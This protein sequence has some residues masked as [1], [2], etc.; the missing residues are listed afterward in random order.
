MPAF[1]K[2]AVAFFTLGKRMG[3]LDMTRDTPE[4]LKALYAALH[5]IHLHPQSILTT[6]EKV[7]SICVCTVVASFIITEQLI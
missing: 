1:L 6:Y 2:T 3:A 5:T 7:K 4:F